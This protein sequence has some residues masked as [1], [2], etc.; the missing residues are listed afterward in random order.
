MM[1][2]KVAHEVAKRMV[3]DRFGF[4][5]ELIALARMFGYNVKQIPVRWLNEENSAV[6]LVGPNGFFRTLRDLFRVKIRL[7]TRGYK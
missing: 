1:T 6:T 5:F 7:I 3:V 4:D 2:G